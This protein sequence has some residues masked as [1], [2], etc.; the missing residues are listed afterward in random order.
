MSRR[1]VTLPDRG[2]L[3][4]A[5]DLQG[6]LR[7]FCAIER[8]FE[9][10]R[11]RH[12]DT[13]LVITGDL[14]HGPELSQEEWPDYLGTYYMGDSPGVLHRAKA[15]QSRHPGHVHYLLG[16]HE[17][18]HV[19]GPV[20]SKFFPDEAERLESLL[21]VQGAAVM[22]S[23]IASWPLSVIAPRCGLAMTHAAPH[24]S[25]S[26]QADLERLPLEILTGE[27]VTIEERTTLL[28]LLWARSTSAE[29]ARSFLSAL[30]ERLAVAVYGHDV[31]P[32]GFAI[33][34]EPMLCISTSFGCFDGDKLYLSWDL[35]RR[36]E[37]AEQV[38]RQGL[39][40]L[41]PDERPVHRTLAC[42]PSA[43]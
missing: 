11:A 22:R 31:A 9:E 40:P 25:I 32:T 34:Q 13:I 29:R 27:A 21:G 6:N 4:V 42:R 37:S 36:A 5:T 3:L 35:A 2:H 43:P 33:D 20:V 41:Y 17:H 39:R 23:W 7:D 10:R 26:S 12:E 38:A 28:S 19:G 18:A 15:L 30:D 8:I 14:V 24:A 1:V 16:N